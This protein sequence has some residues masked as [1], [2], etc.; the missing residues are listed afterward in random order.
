MIGKR[1]EIGKKILNDGSRNFVYYNF[2]S[3]GHLNLRT[4][5]RNFANK[6]KEFEVLNVFEMFKCRI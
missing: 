2:H 4:Y 5:W 6:R 1:K 3:F